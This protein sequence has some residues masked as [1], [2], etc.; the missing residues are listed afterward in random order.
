MTVYTLDSDLAVRLAAADLARCL[1]VMADTDISVCPAEKFDGQPGIYLGTTPSL[2]EAANLPAVPDPKWD[3]AFSLTSAG[4][5]LVIAGTNPRSVLMGAYQYLREL[6]AEWLWPGGDG[7]I[8]PPVDQIPLTGF[9]ITQV[10]AHRHRGVCIEG[11]PSL[12]HIQDMV[13]WMPRVGLN[14]FFLQFQTSSHFWRRW[15]SH[16]LN[17]TW[18]DHWNLTEEEC[19]ALD[20]GVI[21]AVKQ[22]D[23]ILHRV[24]HGWTA[25]ALGLPTNGWDRYEGQVTDEQRKL[26]AKVD[27]ERGLWKNVP[28]NTELCYSNPEARRRLVETV[29]EYAQA[30]PEVDVLH[31]WLSDA[32]NNHCECRQ[33]RQMTPPDWYATLVNQ[34]ALRLKEIAPRMKLALIIYHDLLWPPEQ[35]KVDF[36]R[37]NLLVMF[38]PISRCYGHGL[39]DVECGNDRPLTR[40]SFNQFPL[41]DNNMDHI[42]LLK[43]WQSACPG[44]YFLFDYHFM[45]QWYQDLMSVRLEEVLAADIDSYAQLGLDGLVNCGAERVFYPTGWPYY[46]M[47]RHLWGARQGPEQKARYFQLAFGEQAEVAQRFTDQFAQV[48]GSPIHAGS[49]IWAHRWWEAADIQRANQVVEWL[50]QHREP[51]EAGAQAA[52]SPTQQ[53]AW[54]VL[55]HYHRLAI[56]LWTAVQAKLRGEKQQ[57]LEQLEQTQKFLQEAE[58]DTAPAIDTLVLLG[59]FGAI[60]DAFQ[61]Q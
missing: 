9:N 52:K 15:Y 54:R 56:D 46:L 2:G 10:A 13:Q 57:A 6:G 33:C 37:G 60:R 25:A 3:D 43:L 36:S 38:A 7:E 35:V 18:E 31:L 22:R 34:I 32:A 47:A 51:L 23:L 59:W 11:A 50:A 45:W 58:K 4:D 1:G 24:G 26:M 17:P 5:A 29:L 41:P 27:G 20:E 61:E 14:A 28:I 44:E 39:A 16:Q 55:L 19:A 8:L 49:P 40:P 53:R 21:K 30:H 12:A 42:K 48:T